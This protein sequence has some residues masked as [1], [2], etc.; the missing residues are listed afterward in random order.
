MCDCGVSS[1]CGILLM[2]PIVGLQCVK[3]V[4]LVIVVSLLWCRELVC[5]V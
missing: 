4:F 2:V 3:G 1:D 5:R